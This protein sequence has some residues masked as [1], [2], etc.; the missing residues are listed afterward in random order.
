[1]TS[2]KCL[3]VNLKVRKVDSRS[4]RG[5]GSTQNNSFRP[6]IPKYASPGAGGGATSG[7]DMPLIPAGYM[8]SSERFSSFSGRL[9]QPYLPINLHPLLASQPHYHLPIGAFSDVTHLLQQR[10]YEN[11]C[12]PNADHHAHSQ[13]PPHLVP[14][15][16]ALLEKSEDSPGSSP[17]PPGEIKKI[18]EIVDNTVSK[19]QQ[20]PTRPRTNGL[21]SELLSAAPHP[22]VKSP[23]PHFGA[24]ID[25]RCRFCSSLFDSKIDLH[26]HERYLC[27]R[28]I[29]LRTKQ[30]E[31]KFFQPL[32]EQGSDGESGEESRLRTSP[33]TLSV[34]CVLTLKA[35]YQI[36]PRPKKSELIRL[37]R[38]LK[39]PTRTVQDWFHSQQTRTKDF[40]LNGDMPHTP[41]PQHQQ[42]SGLPFPSAAVPH[43][44]G[45]SFSVAGVPH[46]NGAISSSNQLIPYRPM[47]NCSPNVDMPSHEEDQPL[48]LSFKM[49]REEELHHQETST[50]DNL[51][52]PT[53]FESEVLNLS[54]RSSR[55]PPK[56][57]SPYPIHSRGNHQ[58]RVIPKNEDT[59]RDTSQN[60][61]H[62]S[63][64]YK[65]MQMGTSN[66]RPSPPREKSPIIVMPSSPNR[67]PPH[68]EQ[69]QSMPSP[70]SVSYADNS[71][72][73]SGTT[74]SYCHTD[75]PVDGNPYSPTGGK[76]LRIWN[77]GEGDESTL[78]DC[79][80]AEEDSSG[81][82]GKMRKSWK[83]HK[84]ESEEGMYACDQCDKM[85]SKQS[86]LAR[87]KYEH[88]GQRPHKCDVCSKAFKHKHHLTEHKRLHS[89]EKPFQCKKC[90]K[91][92][93][94]SGS[95]SQHMNH[96]Y[97]YCKPYHE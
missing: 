96:R 27:P 26:Q 43:C 22:L 12:P 53:Q 72:S 85:F 20:S 48:D 56:V 34:D 42:N 62:S 55:T 54:Q 45:H 36:N 65:Y 32:Q 74:G 64:L 70:G 66:R 8:P 30:G 18:L 24:S 38:D 9:Q 6:I 29:E 91:R 5:R 4:P 1:M 90:L 97:S 28:N 21:L 7:P 39:C 76:K 60:H 88:S 3:V 51:P 19:Q 95:Y 2:K 25:T 94:H 15:S 77:Q 81:G 59:G 49:R 69:P 63:L 73:P 80:G 86:S 84:V 58:P 44:N 68:T 23:P 71:S 10:R 50:S 61:L 46:Y 13:L 47:V 78:E 14:T 92:F 93:S 89:G 37:S 52:S 41:P 83:L 11:D 31:S 16:S 75:E 17:K 79:P 82:S 40:P 87:H 33:S 67:S 57:S 35:H